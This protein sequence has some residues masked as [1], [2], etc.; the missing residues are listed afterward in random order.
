MSKIIQDINNPFCTESQERETES[1]WW[2]HKVC[3]INHYHSG[4]DSI[5]LG[6][7]PFPPLLPPPPPS[8]SPLSFPPPPTHTHKHLLGSRSPPVLLRSQSQASN[9]SNEGRKR[10]LLLPFSVLLQCCFASTETVR[11]IMDGEP[12]TATSTCTQLLASVLLCVVVEV[13]LD[14]HRN[15]GF[16]RDGSRT[17]RL[18][19]P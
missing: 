2:E 16:I 19:Q 3:C 4:G 5:V 13:L 1:V 9:K 15:R 11:T 7:V 10:G 8:P 6:I 18:A 17:P 14:V 12:R